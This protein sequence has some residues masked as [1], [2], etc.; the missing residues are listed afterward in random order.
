M[1]I[2]VLHAGASNCARVT[3]LIVFLLSCIATPVRAA[4][5]FH[6]EEATI[7][8]VHQAM[9]AKQ[10]TASQLVNLY[11]KRIEAYNGRCVQGALDAATGLQLGEI[12][13]IENAGQVNALV[14]LNLRGKR[15]KTD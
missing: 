1:R 4:S 5:G 6:L 12:T 15:S 9:K 7:E 14:T 10:L 3:L 13:P 11:L 2:F 8:S